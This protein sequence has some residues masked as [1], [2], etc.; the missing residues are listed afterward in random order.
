VKAISTVLDLTTLGIS[1]TEILLFAFP[2]DIGGHE[3]AWHAGIA[4]LP[5]I[6]DMKRIEPSGSNSNCQRGD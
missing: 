6:A 5:V 4:G 1:L 2:V 3:K